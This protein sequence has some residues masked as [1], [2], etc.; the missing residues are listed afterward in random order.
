MSCSSTQHRAPSEDP[1]HDLAMKSDALSTE[2]SRFMLSGFNMH[3]NKRIHVH[4]LYLKNNP[5]VVDTQKSHIMPHRDY[6]SF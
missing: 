1:P 2:L 4:V 3:M 5:S 6:I